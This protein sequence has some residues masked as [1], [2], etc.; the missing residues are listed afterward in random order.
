MHPNN[1]IALTGFMGSGK[2]TLGGRLATLKK[3]SFIDLDVFIERQ[4]NKTIAKIF[5]DDG[6]EEFR[7]L[8][9]KHLLQILAVEKTTV[10]A[11]GGGT[12]CFHNNLKVLLQNTLLA[13]IWM[14]TGALA[15]RLRTAK[16]ERPLIKGL[17]ENELETFI[18]ETVAKRE[19][20]YNQSHIKVSG[21]DLTAK[22]LN[23]AI[24][25]YL[26]RS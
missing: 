10:L 16:K 5:K 12:V 26:E 19:Q 22:G 1:I 23:K 13:Y 15:Q 6:E 18:A 24:E 14:P 4:E 7:K 20:F 25:Q 2:S 3:F 17:K 8:E 9:N 21:V 11:L